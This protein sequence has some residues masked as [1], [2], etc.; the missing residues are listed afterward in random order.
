MPIFNRN[1]ENLVHEVK[2]Q[3]LVAMQ[4]APYS[5][6]AIADACHTTQPTISRWFSYSLDHI[7]PVY[8]LALLPEEIAMPVLKWLLK[9]FGWNAVKPIPVRQ[10]NNSFEDEC[11][12]IAKELGHIVEEVQ[13]H[14]ERAK[15]IRKH[16]LELQEV[17]SRGL[18][19]AEAHLK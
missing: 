2:E 3:F 8:V 4:E 11:L 18:A 9:R 16:F 6:E 12:D 10:V 1:L 15:I 14:P 17:V 19:E 5:Q 7:P 13:G